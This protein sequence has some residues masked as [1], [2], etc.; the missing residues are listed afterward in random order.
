MDL[1]ASPANSG[2]YDLVRQTTPELWEA[3]QQQ[4]VPV[5]EGGGD[6]V[7]RIARLRALAGEIWEAF[8]ATDTDS[9]RRALGRSWPCCVEDLIE[10]VAAAAIP[11]IAGADEPVERRRE[12]LEALRAAVSDGSFGGLS[13]G[14]DIEA[15]LNAL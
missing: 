11:E 4:L 14:F 8:V 7:E 12:R 10:A 5:A 2:C 13:L 3:F 1:P 15:A 6:P 9:R